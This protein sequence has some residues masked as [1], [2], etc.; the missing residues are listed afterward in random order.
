M[1]E[2][3]SPFGYRPRTP[4][5]KPEVEKLPVFVEF[6]VKMLASG[7]Y[8]GYVPIAPGTCGSV[9]AVVIWY[10]FNRLPINPLAKLGVL[11]AMALVAVGVATLAERVYN[12]GDADTIVIDEMV[13]FFIAASF[14]TPNTYQNEWR[15]VLLVFVLFRILDIVKPFPLKQ[16]EQLPSGWGVVADDVA[17]GIITLLVVGLPLNAFWVKLLDL[18]PIVIGGR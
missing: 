17:A 9:L 6:W 16:L 3:F 5:K 11:A 14:L 1:P 15:L 7:L 12:K 10:Y 13:G 8:T 4:P 2:P 18:H